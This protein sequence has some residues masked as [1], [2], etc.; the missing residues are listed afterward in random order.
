MPGGPVC[1]GAQM[2]GNGTCVATQYSIGVSQAP[3]IVT[4]PGSAAPN[5]LPTAPFVA[6]TTAPAVVSKDAV[7]AQ[8]M[9][10]EEAAKEMTMDPES[11]D[12]GPS[13]IGSPSVS[14]ASATP[15]SFQEEY[16][17]AANVT[18]NSSPARGIASTQPEAVNATAGGSGPESPA[19]R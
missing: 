17:E 15:S 19:I 14:T 13:S 18:I 11:A 12:E 5:I 8:S 16:P 1:L 10:V 7:K 6:G 9:K 2:S 3:P 4:A